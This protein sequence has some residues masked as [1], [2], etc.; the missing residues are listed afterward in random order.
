MPRHDPIPGRSAR[1]PA[2]PESLRARFRRIMGWMALAALVAVL[3]ALIYLKSFGDPVPLHMQIAT[4]LGVGL[5]MLV[6]TGLMGL[7]FLS[8]RSGHD[9]DATFGEWNDERD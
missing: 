9:E 6:G 2:A 5:T 8:S 1:P 7:V 3:L 4:I